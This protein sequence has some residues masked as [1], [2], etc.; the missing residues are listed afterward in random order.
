MTLI[1]AHRGAS[2]AYPENTLLAFAQALRLNVAGIELDLHGCA[3]GIPV[4]IHDADLS[5]TTNGQGSVSD[6]PLASLRLLDAGRG[7]RIPT[8]AEVLDLVGDAVHLDLEVKATGI[9]QAV[10]DL[11][12]AYPGARWAISSF[13]W[14]ILRALRGRSPHAELWPLAEEWSVDLLAVARELGSPVVAVGDEIYDATT[15]QEIA[16]AGLEA[17]IW[18]VNDSATA[19]R[20]RDLGA[21]ALCSD[22]PDLIQTAFAET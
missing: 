18:T 5:R 3:E 9:E 4:V 20:V 12:A 16:N 17:M 2:G 6:T 7:E 21:Y 19:L 15:A 8:L 22:V 14:H 13:E 1:Y 10:L 11:L